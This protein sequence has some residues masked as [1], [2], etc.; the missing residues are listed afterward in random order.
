M[1]EATPRTTEAA[2][3]RAAILFNTA[4][5]PT[6]SIM[7]A[8]FTICRSSGSTGSGFVAVHAD[9]ISTSLDSYQWYEALRPVT[10]APAARAM[11]TYFMVPRLQPALTFR[12]EL[13]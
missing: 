1:L 8:C 3:H 13:K 9:P 11:M 6:A 5:R 7:A 10:S 2:V 4:D 12:R